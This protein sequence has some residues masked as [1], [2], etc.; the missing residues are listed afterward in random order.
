[1]LSLFDLILNERAMPLPLKKGWGD[2]NPPTPSLRYATDNIG[3]NFFLNR[4]KFFS[5]MEVFDQNIFQ[6]F[7]NL[8]VFVI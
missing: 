2:K 5:L 1:V 7:K 4:L 8:V 6:A 3:L